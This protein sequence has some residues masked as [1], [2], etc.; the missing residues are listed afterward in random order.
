[1][2]KAADGPAADD[3]GAA[4]DRLVDARRGD[5]D[6][7]EDDREELPAVLARVG[8]ERLGALVV[9]READG[10]AAVLVRRRI[11]ARD[12]VPAEEWRHAICERERL[13]FAGGVLARRRR[14]TVLRDRQRDEL[15]LSG[16]ANELLDRFLVRFL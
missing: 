15:E 13:A 10:A 8:R 14:R 7:V 6:A 16:R 9:E 3:P 4:R 12:L 5:N 11:R 2:R 1:P